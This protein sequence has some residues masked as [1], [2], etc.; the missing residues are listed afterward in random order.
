[1]DY[2][3]PYSIYLNSNST[4]DDSQVIKDIFKSDDWPTIQEFNPTLFDELLSTTAR[5]NHWKNKGDSIKIIPISVIR[6]VLMLESLITQFYV[7]GDDLSNA[8]RKN[9]KDEVVY[10]QFLLCD[11]LIDQIRLR[12]YKYEDRSYKTTLNRTPNEI[13]AQFSKLPSQMVDL[14]GPNILCV[15]AL[16]V[17]QD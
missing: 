4:S 13:A 2:I 9:M 11:D 10:N 16:D 14:Y 15:K 12:S 1:M 17:K 3:D 7:A 8:T 5:A 6:D